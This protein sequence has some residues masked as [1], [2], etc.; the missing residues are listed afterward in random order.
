ML[1]D[2]TIMLHDNKQ[3]FPKPENFPK[4]ENL[5]MKMKLKLN[6]LIK[7]NNWLSIE[8]TFLQL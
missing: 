7:S 8:P 5:H 2:I 4:F 3:Q 1:E 6:D